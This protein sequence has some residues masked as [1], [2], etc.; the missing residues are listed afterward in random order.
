MQGSSGEA[1]HVHL[2]EAV[3]GLEMQV[4][5]IDAHVHG[6]GGVLVANDFF[7]NVEASGEKAGSG[8]AEIEAAFAEFREGVAAVGTGENLTVY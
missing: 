1:L 4:A 7:L 5:L 6:E 3:T 2:G 8:D